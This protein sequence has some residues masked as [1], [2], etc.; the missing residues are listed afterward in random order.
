MRL[1]VMNNIN[2]NIKSDYVKFSNSEMLLKLIDN[3]IKRL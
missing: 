3:E 2:H 1:L